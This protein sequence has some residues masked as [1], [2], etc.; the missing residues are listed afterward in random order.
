MEVTMKTQ[1][2]AAAVATVLA[3]FCAAAQPANA[4]DEPRQAAEIVRRSIERSRGAWQALRDYTF[5]QT[6]EKRRK[7]GDGKV[8]RTESETEEVL[9][10]EGQP[11]SRVIARNGKPLSAEEQQKERDR[12]DAEIK[13]RLGETPDERA[14]RLKAY[15]EDRKRR[16]AILDEIPKAFDFK[17]AGSAV[18]DDRPVYIVDAYPHPGYRGT[19]KYSKYLPKLKGRLWI[20][21]QDYHWAK[22]EAESIDTVSVGWI[23]ARIQE[24][25]KLVLV[26]KRF[27]PDTWFPQFVSLDAVARVLLVKKMGMQVITQFSDYKKFQADSRVVATQDLPR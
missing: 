3:A 9:I 24:G 13:K 1:V 27:G 15:E 26:Q 10:I 19:H 21:K 14:A 11:F 16:G 18:V 7:D 20:D 6:T 17:L 2:T 4:T 5:V 8:T 25:S 12:M 23:L 22:L